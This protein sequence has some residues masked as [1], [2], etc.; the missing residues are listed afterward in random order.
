MKGMWEKDR[1]DWKWK[2]LSTEKKK[3][4]RGDRGRITMRVKKVIE[5]PENHEE[6]LT[7]RGQR[8]ESIRTN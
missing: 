1:E 3:E 8:L 5:S 7:R 6:R 2:N 4:A